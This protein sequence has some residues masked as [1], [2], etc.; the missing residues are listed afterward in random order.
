MRRIYISGKMTGVENNNYPA[1]FEAERLLKSLGYDTFNPANIN[2]ESDWNW[3]DY[4]KE[5]IKLIPDCTHIYLLKGWETSR[6]ASMELFIANTLGLEV[7]Y[8]K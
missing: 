8:E 3:Q 6:G 1:F 7:M 2:G 5:C 4:M